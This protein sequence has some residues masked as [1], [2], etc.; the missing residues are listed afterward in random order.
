[1]EVQKIEG[2][3]YFKNKTK[4][5]VQYVFSN[6]KFDAVNFYIFPSLLINNKTEE[7]A[8]IYMSGL[9]NKKYTKENVIRLFAKLMKIE[10]RD[11]YPFFSID[12]DDSISG[13]LQEGEDILTY[14][15]SKNILDKQD[16]LYCLRENSDKSIFIEID[17]K[18]KKLFDSIDGSPFVLNKYFFNK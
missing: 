5:D 11:L 12:S 1:M 7:S 8:G 16:Q 6:F 4:K 14:H 17:K 10:S 18:N 3:V 9:V 2:I 13:Q 15:L